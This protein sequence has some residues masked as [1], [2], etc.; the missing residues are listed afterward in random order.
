MTYDE[1]GKAIV[2]AL[3]LPPDRGKALIEALDARY[4]I[5]PAFKVCPSC[6]LA[7][8]DAKACLACGQDLP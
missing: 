8:T 1:A 7:Y 3:L 6:H 5:R 2:A 4:S